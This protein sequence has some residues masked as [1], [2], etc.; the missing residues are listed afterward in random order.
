MHSTRQDLLLEELA[1]RIVAD[2]CLH[3]LNQGQPRTHEHINASGEALPEYIKSYQNYC[4][5]EEGAHQ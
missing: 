5:P 3:L 1:C 4:S 2:A